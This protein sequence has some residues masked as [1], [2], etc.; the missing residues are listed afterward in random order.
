[1]KNQSIRPMYQIGNINKE[2]VRKDHIEILELKNMTTELKNSSEELNS[3][4]ELT[5]K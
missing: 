5:E 3:R 4:Y 2:I 1:M